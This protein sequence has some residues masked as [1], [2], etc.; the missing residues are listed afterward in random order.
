MKFHCPVCSYEIEVEKTHAGKKGR[1][2]GCES[3]FI[4][5]SASDEPVKILKRG[6]KAIVDAF[7]E[8]M[9]KIVQKK[10]LITANAAKPIAKR[11]FKKALNVAKGL[12]EKKNAQDK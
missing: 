7:G 2:L 9:Q 6:N 1:C 12:Q 3:K 8:R 10:L 4:I 5:P 11:W